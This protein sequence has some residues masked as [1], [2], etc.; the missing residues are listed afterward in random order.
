[1]ADIH[2]EVKLL[3]RS[4]LSVEADDQTKAQDFTPQWIPEPCWYHPQLGS[5]EEP[6]C[7]IPFVPNLFPTASGE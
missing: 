6:L 1:M 4:I 3:Q 5:S 7:L 2:T